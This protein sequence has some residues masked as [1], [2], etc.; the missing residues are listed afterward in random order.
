MIKHLDILLPARHKVFQSFSLVYANLQ[1]F[2]PP[3]LGKANIY[4]SNSVDV[5]LRRTLGFS[6]DAL[7]LVAQNPTSATRFI[8]R[9]DSA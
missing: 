5:R 3:W 4:Q 9:Y 8:I 2:T 6:L 1:R 7:Q